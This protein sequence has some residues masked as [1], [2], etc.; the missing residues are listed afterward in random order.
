L[1]SWKWG[2][3]GIV[4]TE[5]RLFIKRGF[6]SRKV[7]EIPYRNISTIEYTRRFSWKTLIFG[8]AASLALFVEPFLR[9][10]FSRAFISRFEEFARLL[11]PNSFLQSPALASFIDIL[12][13]IP[14]TIA[15][16]A[17]AYQAKTSFA[18]RGSGIDALYLP[19]R[20]KEA[21]AFIRNVQDGKFE[22]KDVAN[23][24]PEHDL[25]E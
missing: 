5:Q 9:P 8:A 2:S 17:F 19:S 3:V 10:I 20:F 16:I 22:R 11:F 1:K 18:L 14:L 4:A 25:N 23:R 21:I 6:I 15:V 13:L 7:T 24:E 12:P